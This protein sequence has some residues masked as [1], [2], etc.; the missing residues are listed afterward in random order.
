MHQA[1]RVAVTSGSVNRP[2]VQPAEETGL[3][4]GV[5]VAERFAEPQFSDRATSEFFISPSQLDGVR[6]WGRTGGV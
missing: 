1:A 4:P 5:V 6:L 2:T 3:P